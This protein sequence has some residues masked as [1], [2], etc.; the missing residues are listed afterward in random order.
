MDYDPERKTVKQE[1]LVFDLENQRQV[2]WLE[3]S[4]VLPPGSLIELYNERNHSHGTATVQRVRLLAE[5]K[6][7]T[8]VCLDCEVDERWWDHNLASEA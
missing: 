6:G 8:T 4:H 2:M 5:P 1:T 7:T 3:G